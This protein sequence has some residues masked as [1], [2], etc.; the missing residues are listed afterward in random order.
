MQSC[1]VSNNINKVYAVYRSG[2]LRNIYCYLAK[3][4]LQANVISIFEIATAC[5]NPTLSINR[6]RSVDEVYKVIMVISNSIKPSK[7]SPTKIASTKLKQTTSMTNSIQP[8]PENV[9]NES[10]VSMQD[11]VNNYYTLSGQECK[12]VV[13]REICRTQLCTLPVLTYLMNEVEISK[14]E[15]IIINLTYDKDSA[16]AL[17]SPVVGGYANKLKQSKKESS[18][19][20]I[21]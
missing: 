19:A 5:F 9:D 12:E 3:E 10:I 21:K 1:L 14:L 17:R 8:S 13:L 18:L 2:I 4:E 11:F 20:L 7:P 6:F 15:R 16:R